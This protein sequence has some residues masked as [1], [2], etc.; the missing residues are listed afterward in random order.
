MA[1]A[2]R[3]YPWE[4]PRG[5]VTTPSPPAAVRQQRTPPALWKTRTQTASTRSVAGGAGPLG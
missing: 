4:E 2:R 3:A 5:G 1:A